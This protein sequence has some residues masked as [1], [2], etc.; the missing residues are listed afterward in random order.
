MFLKV[1]THSHPSAFQ[2]DAVTRPRRRN[3]GK[4]Q[5]QASDQD[6]GNDEVEPGMAETVERAGTGEE[7]EEEE[8]LEVV[9]ELEERNGNA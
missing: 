6:K 1:L 2:P 7:E 8:E 5:T 4:K 3:K 9:E